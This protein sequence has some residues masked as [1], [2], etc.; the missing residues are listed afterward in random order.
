MNTTITE[1]KFL[2]RGPFLF[3]ADGTV[4]GIITIADTRGLKVKAILEIKS[5]TIPTARFQIKRIISDTQLI[6][7]PEHTI[8]CLG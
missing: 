1:K 8:L 2:H 7:G 3:T 4:T 5:N 6:V